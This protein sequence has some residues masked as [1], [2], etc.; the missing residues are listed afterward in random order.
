MK[1]TVQRHRLRPN[2]R[3]RECFSTNYES[4]VHSS[5]RYQINLVLLSRK[6]YKAHQKAKETKKKKHTPQFEET[7]Q[8]LEPEIAGMSSDQ[9]FKTNVINML[10]ALM[11]KMET[12][13]EQMETVKVS[14]KE[15]NKMLMLKN[16][17]KTNKTHTL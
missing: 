4:P 12:M 14:C 17:H 9:E 2:H 15:P 1:F 5:S 6:N 16:P 11:N 10:N 3:T 7:E 13:Q 8:L